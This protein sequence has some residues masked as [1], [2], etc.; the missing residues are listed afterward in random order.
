MDMAIASVMRDGLLRRGVAAALTWADVSRE[1]DG[2]GRMLVRRSKTDPDGVGWS[3]TF[4]LRQWRTSRRY[5][6]RTTEAMSASSACRISR[7]TGGCERPQRRRESS[8]PLDDSRE[9]ERPDN[10]RKVH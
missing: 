5:A 4:Q 8:C 3:S 7:Y 10:A 2:S 6:R 1:P 9:V